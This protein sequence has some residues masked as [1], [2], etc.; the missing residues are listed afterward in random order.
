[1]ANNAAMPTGVTIAGLGSRAL[2][3]I[4]DVLPL[5]LLSL[6]VSLL[7]GHVEP[8]VMLVVV[9]ATT[10]LSLGW[11]VFLWWGYATRGQSPAAKWLRIRVLRLADGRPLGWGAYFLRELVWYAT[12]V[13]P[14]VWVVL[15]VMMIVEPR[16]RGWH[17]LAAKSV[18][19]RADL[20]AAPAADARPIQRTTV[21]S[22]NMVGLPPHLSQSSFAVE[23]PA[24]EYTTDPGSGP[25]AA[26]P[27]FAS[28]A[29]FAPSSGFAPSPAAEAGVPWN[30]WGAAPLV[31]AEPVAQPYPQAYN[32][33][34]QQPA[35]YP[36]QGQPQNPYPA[37]PVYQAP[38]YA[39][40]P[41]P[42]APGYPGAAALQ[43]YPLADQPPPLQAQAPR[44]VQPM[45]PQ[46]PVQP[47]VEP[48]DD[49][50]TR[51]HLAPVGKMP[52]APR[53]ATEGWQLRLDDG[54]LVTVEGLVLI[55]RNPQPQASE[56]AHLVQAGV[57]SRMVSKTHLAVGLDHRGLY[58]MD[59]GS[60]NGTAI[61]NA[62]G[63]FE[64]C[65]PGDPVRVREGQIVSFGDRYLE[66][67]RQTQ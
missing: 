9:I 61:A 15:V 1:M 3:A 40:T 48:D 50:L 67:R 42:Q 45:P 37:Q 20:P 38:M 29:G 19:V 25:I 44:P 39:P 30:Q 31:Q 47:V 43:G 46:Q 49:D 21:A 4:L 53:K 8:T 10:L 57:E 26:L 5:S 22:S 24:P 17:D 14:V 51:T 12:L 23:P 35:A 64:P 33:Y 55:G 18:V 58:V 27:D 65:A 16:R 11:A 59:R 13:L 62:G 60:T 41:Q 28:G 34:G 7:S 36:V 2:V 66:V 52:A 54:R 56:Q 32:P 6:L 63:Q